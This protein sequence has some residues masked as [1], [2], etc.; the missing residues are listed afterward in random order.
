MFQKAIQPPANWR[1]QIKFK[2]AVLSKGNSRGTK[3]IMQK[4]STYNYKHFNP[5]D[6][7]FKNFKG[8]SV[9]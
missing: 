9:F 2:T 3:I 8:A 1:K 6:Y 7:N 5:K 4:E